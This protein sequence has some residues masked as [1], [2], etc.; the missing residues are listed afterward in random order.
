MAAW[1]YC[2][3]CL[4]PHK[5]NIT[6]VKD[7]NDDVVAWACLNCQHW[8]RLEAFVGDSSVDTLM[9]PYGTEFHPELTQVNDPALGV[10]NS[11][12]YTCDLVLRD[13]SA[14]C[15]CGANGQP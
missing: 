8:I 15:S 7:S 13:G 2:P 4:A 11:C 10:R 6:S 12:G 1:P 14:S 9:A 5:P 3:N